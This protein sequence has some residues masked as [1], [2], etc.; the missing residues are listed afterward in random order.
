[1]PK[2]IQRSRQRGWKMPPGAVYVG[3]PTKF[4]NPFTVEAYG[5]QGAVGMFA[6][7]LAADKQ[8]LAAV[9]AELAG[10][11]LVCW[12]KLSEPCHADVLLK[13]ANIPSWPL[14]G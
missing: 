6:A 7:K 5:R 1:M 9:R 8:L 10:K 12:C 3:R 4:G 14:P 11:D 2:R 13:A